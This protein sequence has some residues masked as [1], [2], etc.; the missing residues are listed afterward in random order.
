LL[1]QVKNHFLPH[2]VLAGAASDRA[3]AEATAT[4]PLLADRVQLKGQPTAYVC[5]GFACQMPVTDPDTLAQQLASR[6]SR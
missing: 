2:T 1:T 4:I 5:E 3:A 6:P